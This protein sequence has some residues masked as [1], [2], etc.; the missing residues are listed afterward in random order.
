MA[1]QSLTSTRGTVTTL[2]T[3][4][5]SKGSP[6]LLRKPSVRRTSYVRLVMNLSD[7]LNSLRSLAVCLLP[8][9]DLKLELYITFDARLGGP[10]GGYG[11]EP[12][13]G[14]GRT[15]AV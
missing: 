4:E 8:T 15:E 6:W 11:H 9:N 5:K 10:R 1:C 12:C 2:S 3:Q 7:P 13:G 14:M